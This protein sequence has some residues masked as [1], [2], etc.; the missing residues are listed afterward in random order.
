M[1]WLFGVNKEPSWSNIAQLP[2]DP[3]QSGAAAG[4]AGGGGGDKGTGDSG[5]KK[6]VWQ[7]FDPTGLERAATAARDLDKSPNA[8]E[9]LALAMKQEESKQLEE[10]KQI[11]EFEAHVE[12]MKVEQIR[13]QGDEKRKTLSQETR[14]HQD[15]AQ[16][17]D[18]LARKRYEDQLIQQQRMNEENLRRQEESVEK[19]ESMR[20]ST[21]EYEAQL[22]HDN[23]M[24]KLEAELRG[25]ASIE[26]EN[27]DIRA[28]QLRL[29]A[30]EY[31]ETVLQSITAAGTVIGEGF[32]AF[33][34]DWDKVS[35]TAAG[36]TLLAVGV[37]SAKMATGV[38]ARY[39]EARLGKPSLVRETSRLNLLEGLRHPIKTTKR[40]FVKP[41]D[42]LKGIIL[43]PSLEERL[44]EVAIATRNTKRNKGLY[45][46]L[47]FHGP[48]GTGK[49]LFAK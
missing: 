37:Y 16:Y 5:G 20:R 36:L 3:S 8:K 44:R 26:R 19:Q 47:L 31:R 33:I 2:M 23:E 32:K 39:I 17:Q 46:N 24:K 7:G 10:K 34:S 48:P 45:R 12:Q 27:R 40:L 6:Q 29:Q 11:R 22:R 1:S 41:E 49:T 28:D 25:K 15:R 35:A 18:Q 14:Q 42:A 4:G 43:Q 21:I 30:K 9:A 13:T 38:G